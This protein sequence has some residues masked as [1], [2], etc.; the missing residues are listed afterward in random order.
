MFQLDHDQVLIEL[1]QIPIGPQP[2][3]YQTAIG[4]RSDLSR[5]QTGPR[6]DSDRTV[7]RFRSDRDCIL[8][9]PWVNS[10]WNLVGVDGAEVVLA[11]AIVC[12]HRV[13]KN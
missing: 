8:I 1:V 13:Y 4:F 5:I 9:L 12:V 11:M 7:V 2:D 6:P 10:G 3:S